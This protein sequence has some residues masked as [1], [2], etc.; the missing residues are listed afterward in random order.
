[1][2]WFWVVPRGDE[3]TK[4]EKIRIAKKNLQLFSF[5]P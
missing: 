4:A 5:S 1:M 3:E 2:V